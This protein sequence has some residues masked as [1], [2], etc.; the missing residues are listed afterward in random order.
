MAIR[1]YA[2]RLRTALPRV[3]Q[4]SED[5]L[6]R[7]AQA[8]TPVQTGHARDML[9]KASEFVP[10][11][12]RAAVFWQARDFPTGEFYVVEMLLSGKDPLTPAAEA[13]R[14]ILPR[15]LAAATRQAADETRP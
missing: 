15:E 8:A 13:E 10:V 9:R 3:L 4:A 11:E 6:Y 5:R 2:R 1:D 12:D 14:P 7:D